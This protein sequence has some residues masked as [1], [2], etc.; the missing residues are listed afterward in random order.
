MDRTYI[1]AGTV[2]YLVHRD[3]KNNPDA[4][5]RASDHIGCRGADVNLACEGVQFCVLF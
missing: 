2:A 3:G 5:Q 1:S 4:A